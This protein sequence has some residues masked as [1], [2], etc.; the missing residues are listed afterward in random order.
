MKRSIAFLIAIFLSFSLVACSGSQY[1][2]VPST[3]EEASTV[4]TLTLGD[5]EYEVKYELYRALFLTY[6]D[7]VSGGDNSVWQGEDSDAYIQKIN[8]LILNRCAAIY[9]VFAVCEDIG[10]D[11]YSSEV[12]KQVDEYVASSI[13]SEGGYG[14]Y[15]GYLAALHSMNLNWS[16][17]DL[18]LRYGIGLS[19]IDEYYIGDFDADN[20]GESIKLGELTYT[21][22]DVKAYYESDEC[23][24]V[25]RA[26]IQADAYYDPAEHAQTVKDRME[27]VA[28]NES[29]VATV[30]INTGLTA[31]TEVINGYVIGRN[32]LDALYYG[33]MTE[34]AFGLSRGEVSEPIRVHNG[35]ADIIFILYRAEKSDEHFDNCYTEIAYVYLTDKVGKIIK[36]A[37]DGLASGVQYTA[38]FEALDYAAITMNEA[39]QD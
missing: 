28:G 10:Y 22:E 30:I 15:E 4:M 13:E 19:A 36:E 38:A 34:A 14:S 29:A 5:K 37:A 32:N 17:Q 1:E 11:L 20:L 18:L 21:R 6:R 23:V 31:P 25:L 26:H 35:E 2:P 39:T 12:D 8:T 27:S 16:V 9:S 3:D 7:E 24:R 33:D